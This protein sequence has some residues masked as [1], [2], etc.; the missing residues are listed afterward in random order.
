MNVLIL[1]ATSDIAVALSVRLAKP[2]D[3]F[4]LTGRNREELT[5]LA[6]DLQIRTQAQA[7][8]IPFD[9]ADR[10][11]HTAFVAEIVSELGQID[12]V[13]VAFGYLGEQ[14]KAQADPD[15]LARIIEVN[16]TG[17]ASVLEPLAAHLEAR[18]TGWILGLSSVAGV[19]GRKSN[20]IYGSAKAAFTVYLEGL[21]HRL[22]ARGV[23][24]KIAKLGFVASKMTRGMSMPKW[25]IVSPDEAARGLCWLLHSSFQ[26]AYIPW[27]WW[28]IMTIIRCLPARLF[29]RTNL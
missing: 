13:I 9:A 23:A 14:P 26:S 22:A 11:A 25:A 29:S 27:R 17:A 7:I 18:S 24:V 5:A 15:E 1:G 2:G 8:A 10:A 20:Y 6:T 12:G 4:A 3:R 28:P 21:A 19:R 16:F